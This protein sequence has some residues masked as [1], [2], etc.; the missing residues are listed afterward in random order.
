MA[1]C[2]KCG[3]EP[4]AKTEKTIQSALL[5]H[6]R[7]KHGITPG[8]VKRDCE[9]ENVHHEHGT[10][11]AYVNDGCRCADCREANRLQQA[12]RNRAI[13]YGRF[14][15]GKT[16]AGPARAHVL[17]LRTAGTTLRHISEASGVPFNVVKTLVYGRGA[18]AQVRSI[19]KGYADALLGV[20]PCAEV[21]R[22]TDATGTRRRL[23]ALV[24]VGHAFAVIGRR[25][26]MPSPT[27]QHIA[28]GRRPVVQ[29]TTE[30][31]VRALYDELWD[32]PAPTGG[33]PGSVAQKA[34][35]LAV[36]HG[37][38]PPMAWDD[39]EIDD[40]AAVPDTGEPT[41]REE[42]ITTQLE[43]LDWLAKFGVNALEAADRLGKNP[44]SLRDAAQRHGR[45]DLARKMAYAT[46][47][48]L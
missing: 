45:L 40:P 6:L 13:A 34:R 18:D 35:R 46:R 22:Y 8:G 31:K 48:T 41:P 2:L 32:A 12:N 16:P 11:Q 28:H 5:T 9:H 20:Q 44:G 14:T 47:G 39:D 15:D 33:Y 19:K 38:V 27:L 21:L 23:Q 17:S 36:K 26:G 1:H 37:W 42:L 29:R 30:A 10:N 7:R 25:L 24:A 3:F 4:K 43:D